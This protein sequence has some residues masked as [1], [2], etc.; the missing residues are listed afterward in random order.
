[1]TLFVR[2]KGIK[3]DPGSLRAFVCLAYLRIAP[4]NRDAKLGDKCKE[5]IMIGYAKSQ[6]GYRIMDRKTQQI[7][8]AKRF[9]QMKGL[10]Y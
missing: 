3:L 6:K 9:S 8:V 7:S 1:M 4:F 2:M 5:G 10:N